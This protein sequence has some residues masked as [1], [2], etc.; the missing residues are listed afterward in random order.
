MLRAV[1]DPPQLHYMDYVADSGTNSG[2]QS[3][4]QSAKAGETGSQK[5][6]EGETKKEEKP[7]IGITLTLPKEVYFCEEPQVVRW[8]YDLKQWRLDGFSDFNFSEGLF[9]FPTTDV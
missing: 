8:D 5:G 2:N 4:S 9:Q 7:P 1:V 3:A 6:S